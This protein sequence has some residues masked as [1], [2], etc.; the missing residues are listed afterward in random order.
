MRREVRRKLSGE[1]EGSVV[2][3]C[4]KGRE[5]GKEHKR[6]LTVSCE[7]DS[8]ILNRYLSAVEMPKL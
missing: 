8:I 5:E 4:S 6:P 2:V 1:M 7:R 3:E